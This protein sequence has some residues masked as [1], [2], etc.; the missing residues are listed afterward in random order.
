[1]CRDCGIDVLF[2]PETSQ[3]YRG[4]DEVTINPPKSMGY[5]YEGFRRDG[6]FDGVL[7]VVVKLLNLFSPGR[8]YFGQKDAQQFLLLQKMAQDLFIDC[9]LIASPTQRDSDGL[10]LSSRNIY[11]SKE[12]R[13]LAL[14]IPNSLQKISQN[15]EFGEL[16]SERLREIA[17]GELAGVD[18]EYLAFVDRRL[19]EVASLTLGD[20]I[21]LIAAKVGT[22]RLIDN[23][24]I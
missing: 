8:A 20:S 22:T 19:K 2:M 15:I 10:A 7:Q 4:S 3:I 9:E 12:D 21:V 6:H 24:W 1:M 14:K 18:V 5:V 16:L 13:E 11:L 17:M 23:L